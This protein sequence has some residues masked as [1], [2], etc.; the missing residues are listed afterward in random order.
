MRYKDNNLQ[1]IH[2]ICDLIA[3]ASDPGKALQQVVRTL[4]EVTHSV[5]CALCV[6]EPGENKLFIRASHGLYLDELQYYQPNHGITGRAI[7]EGR[8]INTAS[9]PETDSH[10]PR[11]VGSL[12]AV[13]LFTSGRAIGTIS[14]GRSARQVFPSRFV[15]LIEAVATP[16]ASYILCT[17]LTRQAAISAVNP[18]HRQTSPGHKLE[19]EQMLRGRMIVDGVTVGRALMLSGATDLETV[20]VTET[21][22]SK[23]NEVRL[24]DAAIAAAADQSRVSQEIG[25]LLAEA[26]VTIFEMHMM[27]LKDP[28]LRNRIV[29]HLDK[30]LR[31]DCA[32]RLTLKE[33]TEEYQNI[34]DEYLRERLSDIKDVLLRVK[35][36]ADNLSVAGQPTS[37]EGAEDGLKLPERRIILVAKELLPSQL[38]TS[39]LT[40][41]CGIVC[42]NA[43]ATSHAAI[44][45]K[46]LRIPML[47]SLTGVFQKVKSGDILLVDCR[48]E[49]CFVKPS[50]ELIKQYSNPLRHF[51]RKVSDSGQNVPPSSLDDNPK[52]L[53]GTAVHLAGNIT[54]LSEMPS[55]RANG[56]RDVGLYRTE[57]MFMIRNSMPDEEEQFRILSRLVAATDGAA[58]N[59]R[60]LDI[61]GDKPLSYFTWEHEDNPSLGWRGLR[62]LLSNEGFFHT[63]LRAMLRASAQGQ[64][65]LLFP[66]IS[67]CGDVRQ[68]RAAMMQARESLRKDGLPYREDADFGMMLEL[69]SAVSCLD[70]LLPE[71]DFVCIGTND[72]LQYMF[73]VDRS[74]SYVGRWYRQLHPAIFRVLQGICRQGAAFPGKRISICGELAGNILALP[75]L[76]GCGLRTL[77]MAPGHIPA[78]RDYVRKLD[79]AECQELTEKVLQAD[80]ESDVRT[81]LEQFGRSHKAKLSLF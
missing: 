10:V 40:Q 47:G 72:L 48:S 26:D 14:L 67:D 16:L 57:F 24:L 76:L 41:I 51:R 18:A 73:A 60:A 31:L 3:H 38:I 39:P 34:E 9:W 33:F 30:G 74:N 21:V 50:K 46:A 68:A 36:A 37:D 64:V 54:L 56:I 28:T 55:L 27:L 12:L 8:T 13:P 2:G 43:G 29:Q 49:L 66:M 25:G 7:A 32:L 5:H 44:L 19:S 69:P 11:R 75:V 61:G 4:A 23:E 15:E 65:N 22:E 79:L 35:T 80:V 81:L 20:P 78:I 1:V 62:F 42:E 17:N 71:V 58:L 59:I 77:S 6:M 45:A 70:K 63:H 52:T 53:D